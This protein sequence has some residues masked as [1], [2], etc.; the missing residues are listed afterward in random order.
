MN[1]VRSPVARFTP[2]FY[3]AS[4]RR[5]QPSREQFCG[6]SGKEVRNMTQATYQVILS[7]DG[8]QTVIVTSDNAEEMK[9][10]ASWASATYEL[11]VERYVLKGERRQEN[12]EAASEEEP[13]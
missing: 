8:K 2:A 4:K 6:G 13:M 9:A 7:T 11:L 5:Q 10:A 12:A 3:F 1:S